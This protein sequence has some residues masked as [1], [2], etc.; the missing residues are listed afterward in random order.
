MG[1][2]LY[3]VIIFH[4]GLLLYDQIDLNY[5]PKSTKSINSNKSLQLYK[6]KA[7]PVLFNLLFMNLSIEENILS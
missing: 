3:L 1:I 7:S 5:Y 2:F 6:C 4:L